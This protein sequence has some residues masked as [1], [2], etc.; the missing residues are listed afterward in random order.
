MDAIKVEIKYRQYNMIGEILPGSSPFALTIRITDAVVSN[1][2]RPSKTFNRHGFAT[3][4][5]RINYFT[6][7]ISPMY[8]NGG[9]ATTAGSRRHPRRASG[10]PWDS[11]LRHRYSNEPGSL[12][13]GISLE[14]PKE[15]SAPLQITPVTTIS[16]NDAALKA[17]QAALGASAL[18]L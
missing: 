10:R 12:G 6:T 2:F 7:R 1:N 13:P 18:L 11:N 14:S 4:G 15:N 3:A 8:L 17:I 5:R 16:N 9:Y